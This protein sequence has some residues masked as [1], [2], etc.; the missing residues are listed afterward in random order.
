MTIPYS[1][2]ERI[3]AVFIKSGRDEAAT[4][5]TAL[6]HLRKGALV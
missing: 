1:I 6:T 3:V 4:D 2:S 5:L